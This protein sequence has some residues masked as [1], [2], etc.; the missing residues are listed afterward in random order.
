MKA[1]IANGHRVIPVNPREASIEGVNCISSL[2]MLP[3]PGNTAISVVTPPTVS[4][5]ILEEAQ[6]LG[7]RNIWF[8]PGSYSTEVI[9]RAQALN[10]DVIAGGFCVLVEMKPSCL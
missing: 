1:Y 3:N 4:L 5:T 8:Q 9:E 6:K 7:C 2:K 10:M